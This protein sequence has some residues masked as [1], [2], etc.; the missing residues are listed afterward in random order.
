M[1]LLE[2]FLLKF[3]R[4]D[5]ARNPAFGLLDTI[6]DAHPELLEIVAAD[7]TRGGK[8][9]EFGRQ[10]MPS[11]EQIMRAAIF[12]AFKGLEYRELEEAQIDSR[13]CAQFTKIDPERPYS[14]QVFQKYISKISAEHL[15][16]LMHGVVK[17]AIGEGLEDVGSLRQDSTV[18]ETNIHY[19]TNNSLVWDCVKESQRLLAHLREEIESL[20]FRDYTKG[21]KRTYFKL[22]NTKSA[23]KRADLFKKQLATFTQCINQVANVVKKKPGYDALCSANPQGGVIASSLFAELERLLP[24]MRRVHSMTLRKEINGENV[25]NSD[26]IFSIYEQHTDLIVKGA[27]DVTFGH[28][29]QLSSGRSGLLLSCDILKGNPSDATQFQGTLDRV[30]S[31]YGITPRDSATDGGYASLANLEHAKSKG[32]M[33]IVFN[34]IV[35]SLKNLATSQNM[36]TRLKKWRSGMEAVISNLKRG[37][38]LSRCDWKGWEHFK[39]KVLWSAIAYNLRVMTARFLMQA[40][41]KLQKA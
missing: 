27:R 13:I 12:K 34:K 36:E 29:V 24:V 41:L 9:S 22:N 5:W 32:I 17:V 31:T 14:F 18:V 28:K 37:F 3:E 15:E 23:D 30:I 38:G 11:V 25:P 2:P 40:R 35:G 20:D 6:L 33:N 16:A 7:V 8:A 4:P 1:K 10:D 21:A 39:Q 26:K 19:P